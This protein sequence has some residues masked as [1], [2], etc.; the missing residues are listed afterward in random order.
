MGIFSKITDPLRQSFFYLFD[1]FL[2][3]NS[4]RSG[5]MDVAFDQIIKIA[6]GETREFSHFFQSM[7]T[8]TD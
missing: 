5:L 7:L 6:L 2:K 1:F 4:S 3:K 8:R